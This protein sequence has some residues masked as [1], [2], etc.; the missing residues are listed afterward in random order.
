MTSQHQCYSVV[1]GQTQA[2][3]V[4][5]CVLLALS[6]SRAAAACT[7]DTPTH[8]RTGHSGQPEY[9]KNVDSPI[10]ADIVQE[11]VKTV[12]NY[13]GPYLPILST[14]ESIKFTS[15]CTTDKNPCQISF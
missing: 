4:N 3:S 1:C 5:V 6:V 8:T 15:K 14:A 11:Q 13:K 12:P 10:S 7:S 9:F 2:Q